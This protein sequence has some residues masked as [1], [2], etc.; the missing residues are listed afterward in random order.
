MLVSRR[1]KTV[2]NTP[3][4]ERTTHVAVV[5]TLVVLQPHNHLNLATLDNNQVWIDFKNVGEQWHKD[6]SNQLF[7]SM[8]FRK[9]NSTV[10]IPQTQDLSDAC[11]IKCDLGG[12]TNMEYKLEAL[13]LLIIWSSFPVLHLCQGTVF[14]FLSCQ[15]WQTVKAKH[16][17]CTCWHF[18][19]CSFTLPI[20][21]PPGASWRVSAQPAEPP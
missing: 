6:S 15:T 3:R 19:V 16:T 14:C 2:C 7:N 9:Q 4:W 13:V 17:A 5:F 11:V 10:T 8:Y 20:W 1:V 12:K 18:V 21:H